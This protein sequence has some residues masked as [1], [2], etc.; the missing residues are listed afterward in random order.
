V[1]LALQ[2]GA[3]S[4]EGRERA[5]K[6]LR[7]A[8]MLDTSAL[9]PLLSLVQLHAQEKD[10]DTC[11]ELLKQG[12]EGQTE[13][14]SNPVHGREV[15]YTKL[16]ETYMAAENYKEA[17]VAFHSALAISPMNTEVQ[18]CVDRLEAVVRGVEVGDIASVGPDESPTGSANYA[19][20][21]PSY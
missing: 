12:I 18:N 17:L 19:G 8:L 5:K 10:F 1:G 9:R 16:G 15:L 4:I 2:Q 6:T 14:K 11:V 7:K 3:E 21:R 20:G 13:A